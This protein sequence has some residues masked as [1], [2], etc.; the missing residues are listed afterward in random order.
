MT[1]HRH[2]QPGRRRSSPPHLVV[3]HDDGST[4]IEMLVG[5]VVMSIGLA[6]FTTATVQI[7]QALRYSERVTQVHDQLSTAFRKVEKEVR[8]ALEINTPGSAVTKGVDYWYVEYVT[9]GSTDKCIQ[10]RVPRIQAGITVATSQLQ[11]RSWLLGATPAGFSAVASYI[12]PPAT[13]PFTQPAATQ[14]R[15]LLTASGD[16]SVT[17]GANVAQTDVVFTALNSTGTTTEAAQC[18]TQR[19]YEP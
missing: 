4:L 9:S 18:A 13:N 1:G 3:R 2:P 12:Q 15:M 19:T 8:Y 11:T 6:I 5:M 14:L 7:Y 10:L 17:T 16:P